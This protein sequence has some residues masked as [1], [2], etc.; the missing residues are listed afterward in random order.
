MPSDTYSSG[1]KHGNHSRN[2]S[3]NISK[4]ILVASLIGR[5][6]K[7]CSALGIICPKTVPFLGRTLHFGIVSV[8]LCLGENGSLDNGESVIH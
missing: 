2:A 3:L 8:T 5:C 4:G 6:S 7:Q 1:L